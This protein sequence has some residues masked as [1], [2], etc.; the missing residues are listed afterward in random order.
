MRGRRP[1][2]RR[3][4]MRSSATIRWPP[5]GTRRSGTRG[6]RSS[7]GTRRSR[8]R[9]P[10]RDRSVKPPGYAAGGGSPRPPGP[11]LPWPPLGPF[12]HA[13]AVFFHHLAAVE[14][15]ALGLG[16]LCQ[17][18]KLVFRAR[19]WQNILRA[20]YPGHGPR[21]RSAL[22]AYV[23]GVGVN[24]I[25]PAR[26]GD[27]VKL[28]LIKHRIEGSTLRDARRR[29][30]SSRR[31]STSSSAAALHHLGP[32]RSACCPRT[33]STRGIPT[34]D[35]RFFLRHQRATEIGLAILAVAIVIAVALGAPPGGVVLGARA[36]RLCDS[37]RPAP[38]RDRRA[39]AA[40]D[41]VG[42][43]NRVALLLPARRSAF[44]RRCT[45][46]CSRRSS[47]RWRR[48]SRPRP[49]GQARS[50]G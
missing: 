12:F 48:C 24:S 37:R 21:F 49:A 42:A 7:P 34:V 31:C 29:R 16:I 5:G 19:A 22:G 11:E 20:S 28:Y 33:R 23:A 43:A 44:M 25:A 1:A 17:V 45:T 35:W 14:W 13:V 32:R 30:S 36:A 10:C 8:D 15:S 46:R 41:L 39:R 27:L 3:R 6:S 18:L 40:G 26:G 4:V 47:T 9:Q 2:S 50:R 38:A